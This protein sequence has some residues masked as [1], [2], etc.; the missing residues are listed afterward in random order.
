MAQ[1]L[2]K[3]TETQVEKIHEKFSKTLEELKTNIS[4]DENN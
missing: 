1:D 4:E 2:R 3:R